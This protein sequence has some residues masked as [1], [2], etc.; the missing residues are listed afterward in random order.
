MKEIESWGVTYERYALGWELAK[1]KT[2]YSIETVAEMPAH[3]AKAMPSIYSIG[4][5]LARARVTLI[6]SVV[7]YEWCWNK[8]GLRDMVRFVHA[9]S[10]YNTNIPDNAFDFVWNF[11]YL[12]LEK[13]KHRL[14]E[15]MKRISRRYVA[16]FSVNYGNTGFHIHRMLH[17]IK[18][19]SWTHGDI[20]YNKRKKIAL[21]M[22]KH[23]FRIVETGFVDCPVWPD[24]LGFRDMRLHRQNVLFDE[25]Q[26]ESPY[27]DNLASGRV[28]LWI[29]C[30]Y[31]WERIPNLSFIKTLYAH[32]N[33]IIGKK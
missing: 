20:Y 31:T 27:I 29:K 23:G 16:F 15:E 28:P 21:F 7:E 17:K 9:D 8:V 24:S 22:K 19:V 12:P 32:V 33:Y 6:N 4:F 30:V 3:G 14:I 26:W 5:G 10:I 1:L 13:D 25:T 2:Q 18:N 11:A